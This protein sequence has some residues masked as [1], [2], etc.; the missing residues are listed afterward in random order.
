M[1]VTSTEVRRGDDDDGIHFREEV[2]AIASHPRHVHGGVS[3]EGAEPPEVAISRLRVDPSLRAHRVA[4]PRSWNEAA[5]E[6]CPAE[7]VERAG[8]QFEPAGGGGLAA[9]RLRPVPAIDAER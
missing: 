9:W 4:E 2:H 6:V 7:V 8:R 5:L 3:V 1:R